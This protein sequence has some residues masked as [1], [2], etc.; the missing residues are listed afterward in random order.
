METLPGLEPRVALR[1]FS[2][3]VSSFLH[4]GCNYRKRQQRKKVSV[5]TFRN[6][7]N[8]THRGIIFAI[9]AAIC[10][11]SARPLLLQ[12][13]HPRR[14]SSHERRLR[15]DRL[16]SRQQ[17]ESTDLSSCAPHLLAH[18]SSP[19]GLSEMTSFPANVDF[20]ISLATFT[21]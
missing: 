3:S 17:H 18:H 10:V 13:I 2:A 5:R 16:R 14:L 9:N 4:F 20:L 1:L 11:N 7:N 6:A 15:R 12:T 21:L 8:E 19:A